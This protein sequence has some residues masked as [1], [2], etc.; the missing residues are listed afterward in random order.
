MV[1]VYAIHLLPE[2]EFL[3]LKGQLLGFLPEPARGRFLRFNK[4]ADAQRSLLGDILARFLISGKLNLSSK[5]V[6][7]EIGLNGKPTFTTKDNLHFNISH[8]GQWVVCALA[9]GPVG[10]DVERLRKVNSGLAERFFSPDEVATIRALPPE[11]QTK[12][13]IQLWA[14]KESFLKAIGRGLTRNLNSFSI[15]ARQDGMYCITGDDSAGEFHLKLFDIE[16]DYM[17]AACAT[18]A[19]FSENVEIVTVQ[20][21]LTGLSTPQ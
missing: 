21:I 2:E 8:S 6:L 1:E 14:L 20:Q 13:F 16:P 18:A 7:F 19:D 4:G 12:K 3:K 17:L 5:E 11:N 10:V 15:H 9:S